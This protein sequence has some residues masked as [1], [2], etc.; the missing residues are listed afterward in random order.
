MNKNKIYSAI[1]N[2]FV[3]YQEMICIPIAENNDDM[4][5]VA[6][7]GLTVDLSYSKLEPSTGKKLMLRRNVCERL[8]IA[9]KELSAIKDG[10]KLILIYAY[11]S[12]E[13]QR[14]N[15][16]KMK[17]E[18]GYGS[19]TDSEALESTHRFI[20]VPDVAGHPTGAAIDLLIIDTTS[21]P[22]DFGTPMHALERNSYVFCPYV[23]DEA[24]L[25]RKLLR[26]VMQASGFAP[27]DGE[28]WHFSYGDREW[29][30]YY[31]EP[32]AF[33]SQL[34]INKAWL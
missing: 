28:W 1:A 26:N 8:T 32:L 13:I 11:R 21:T 5:D 16:E 4:V 12:L 24:T 7:Y 14:V 17:V 19:R 25:N 3:N 9:Q 33:Y 27:Y 18:L 20:A 23:S 2:K 30:A 15:F 10:Y 6:S 29:A 22:L 34:E 31:K